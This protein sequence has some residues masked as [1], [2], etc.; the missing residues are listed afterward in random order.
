MCYLC[1]YVHVDSRRVILDL[2]V[3]YLDLVEV[4]Q[5][6]QFFGKMFISIEDIFRKLCM[7]MYIGIH[8]RLNALL[9]L[10]SRHFTGIQCSLKF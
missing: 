8:I 9:F 4:F 2:E 3:E 10:Q 6:T 5:R 1:A 7:V